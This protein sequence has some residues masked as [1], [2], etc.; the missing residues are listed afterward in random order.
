MPVA[1]VINHTHWD[2]EWFLTHEYTTAWIPKLI[3]SLARLSQ[4]NA[5]YEFLIDGQTLVIEDLLRTQPDYRTTVEELISNGNLSIGP[6]Y[7]QPDWRMVSGELQMRNLGIG[8]GDA[9]SLGGRPRVAWLVDTFGHISQAPQILAQFGI[10][11][12]YVWRGVPQMSPLFNW[13]GPDGTTLTAVDLFGGYRN[14]YGITKTADIAVHRLVAEVQKLTPSY[15]DLPIPLFDGYDLDTEPEDP[16]RYY[17]SQDVPRE[18]SVV[19]SSPEAY[20]DAILPHFGDAPTIR[21]ELLSGKFGSTFPGSL[22]ARTYLKVLHHDSENAL[23]RRL[24]PLAVMASAFGRPYQHSTYESAARELLQNGVHDCLCGVSIDQVHERMERSYRRHLRFANQ[25]QEELA[26]AILSGFADGFYAISSAAM[27]MSGVLRT[28]EGAARFSTNG[29]GVSTVDVAEIQRTDEPVDVVSFENDHYTV[30]VTSDGLFLG[31]QNEPA[32]RI[33]VRQ[34]TGD[35]YSSEPGA[36]LGE[37]V[38]AG[39]IRQVDTTEFDQTI[40]FESTFANEEIEVTASVL[41]RFDDGP[42][43]DFTI[44]LDS[45]GTGFRVDAEF[46]TLVSAPTVHASMPFDVVQRS[47]E[48]RDLFGHDVGDAMAAILMGQR[49]TGH[50]TEFPFH[51]F[52]AMSGSDRTVAVLAKGIR[53]YQSTVAGTISVTLRRST[54]WLARTNLQLRSGD[55]GP[56]MY[57][58]GARSERKV[59][60]RIGLAT[61]SGDVTDR[62]FGAIN[63]QFHNPPLIAQVTGSGDGPNRWDVFS[64]PLPLTGLFLDDN[65]QATARLFNPSSH[66]VSL[67][68]QGSRRSARGVDLGPTHELRGKEIAAM[69]VAMPEP[70]ATDGDGILTVLTPIEDRGGRSRSLPTAEQLAG[71][72]QRILVLEEALAAALSQ[73]ATASG[74]E[75]HLLTHRQCVVERE[76]LELLLSRELNERLLHSTD[77]VSIGDDPDPV[78]AG[79]GSQLND[80]RVKRRIYDYVAQA[81]S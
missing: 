29:V 22:S 8:I 49:E 53:S 3:D 44:D 62:W 7:S 69:A 30:R 16:V 77:E 20:V 2:R 78:I 12:A 47:H 6:V 66:S 41:A 68:E 64:A 72:D 65:N 67:F 39:S 34:D 19:A 81:L 27:P 15:G 43:I 63:E 60:H 55:A 73:L 42:M 37:L 23:H 80:L 57:V 17:E 35:T 26:A 13:E 31:G 52:V 75:H 70:P 48:D 50:V 59:R 32:M 79:L 9:E 36:V 33:L 28:S 45:T 4:E 11:A 74:N 24:E 18:I 25:H 21:G 40:G 54:E 76:L 14:L 71:L 1:H 5:D 10:D 51:D 61:C 38:V 46:H 56:M 58:P